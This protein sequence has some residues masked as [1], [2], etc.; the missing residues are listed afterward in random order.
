MVGEMG[1]KRVLVQNFL[2]NGMLLLIMKHG[3]E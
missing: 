1:S 2:R 3:M